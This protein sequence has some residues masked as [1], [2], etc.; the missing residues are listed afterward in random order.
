MACGDDAGNLKWV[1]VDWINNMY[2]PSNPPLKV[3]SKVERGL[4][5]DF[6]GVLLCPSEWN[7][8][9]EKY[10]NLSWKDHCY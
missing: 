7:W 4:G 10:C 5:N 1:V 2:G 6:T 9:D 8:D 3:K